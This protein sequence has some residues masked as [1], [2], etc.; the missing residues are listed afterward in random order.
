MLSLASKTEVNEARLE[1]QAQFKYL[2]EISGTLESKIEVA[3]L[4]KEA[5][6]RFTREIELYSKV[7]YVDEFKSQYVSERDI[8]QGRIAKTDEFFNKIDSHFT[9]IR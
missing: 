5:N 7:K 3:R 6:D 1:A 8:M 2:K 4:F 9:D